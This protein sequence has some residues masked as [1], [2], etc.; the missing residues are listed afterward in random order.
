MGSLTDL[1]NAAS[2][3]RSSYSLAKSFFTADVV[4]L[5]DING[6]QV[7][8]QCRAMSVTI[9]RTSTLAEHPL[10]TG[11]TI[12]DFKIIK[13]N[14]ITLKMMIPDDAYRAVYQQIEQAWLNSTTF[15]VQTWASSFANMVIT[16]LPHDETPASVGSISISLTLKEVM[17]FT[18]T[19]ETM[20]A[21]E[22]AVS[23]KSA[24]TGGKAKPDAVTVKQGQKSAV[25]ATAATQ[26]KT[27]AVLKS[28]TGDS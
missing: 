19:V 2:G 26:K 12:T 18:S 17:W 7:F 21:K 24:K 1:M 6:V 11:N 10:E 27:L 22:V 5:T 20:P 23:T 28:Q 25:N 16:D 8:S 15:I 3:V 9:N 14:V 4:R 13:P